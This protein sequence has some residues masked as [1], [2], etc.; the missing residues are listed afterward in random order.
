MVVLEDIRRSLVVL[1]VFLIPLRYIHISNA[2][3]DDWG[4][5]SSY[6]SVDCRYR[7]AGLLVTLLASIVF[8]PF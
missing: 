2:T 7:M 1:G 3:A 8:N 6:S 5:N 4:Y